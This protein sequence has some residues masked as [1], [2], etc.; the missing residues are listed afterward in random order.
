M[1]S[2]RFIP[3]P[4]AFARSP[5]AAAW[6]ADW[7]ARGFDLGE[8]LV[9]EGDRI[10]LDLDAD[11]PAVLTASQAER[12]N[13][14]K[15]AEFHRLLDRFEVA[16]PPLG[17]E[18]VAEPDCRSM[19]GIGGAMKRHMIRLA[20]ELGTVDLLVLPAVRASILC[21]QNRHPPAARATAALEA[22]GFDRSDRMAAIGPVGDMAALL[23]PLMWIARCNA[24]APAI[25]IALPGTPLCGL[26]CQYGN[27][28]FTA[29][30]RRRTMIGALRRSGFRLPGDGMCRERFGRR[31]GIAGRR[32]DL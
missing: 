8:H 29:I 27:V 7:Q 14:E 25:V 22:A 2:I 4:D 11:A 1:P 13:I 10:W 32:I 23:G 20:G 31:P 30:D 15:R 28:H 5:A 6:I 21:Q 16:L 3:R 24:S 9:S 17:R 26:L 12:F 18:I 19:R